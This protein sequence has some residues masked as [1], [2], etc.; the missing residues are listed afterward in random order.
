MLN[1]DVVI[2]IRAKTIADGPF[3]MP[4]LSDE[5]KVY[6]TLKDSGAEEKYNASKEGRVNMIRVDIN[7][8]EYAGEAVLFL[9]GAEKEIYKTAKVKNKVYLYASD[10][11][12]GG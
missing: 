2:D 12:T 9:D 6:G 8:E 4:A 10:A 5:K 7:E 3:Q 1:R 11:K